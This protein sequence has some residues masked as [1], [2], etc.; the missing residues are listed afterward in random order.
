MKI[1]F[2]NPDKV[3]GLLTIT[4]E[5]TDYK[6]EVEKTLKDYRKKANFPGFRPGMVPMGLIKRQFGASVKMDAINKFVGEQI[7]KYVKD[8]NINMLGQPMGSD[9]QEPQD[10]EKPAPYTFMFDIAVAPDFKIELNG[11]DKIV[12]YNIKVDDKLIDQQVEMFASRAGKYEAAETYQEGD[13]LKGDLRELDENGNKEGGIEVSEAMIMPSYIKVDDQKKLFDGAKVGDIIT[14]N[15]RK[16]YPD[17]DTEVSS[18]LKIK[19]EELKDHEGDFSFQVTEVSHF[20]NHAIDQEL[21]DSVFGKDVVKDEKGFR[22]K[23]AEGLKAQLQGDSDYR[24]LQD[25]REYCAKKVGQLTYPDELL[26]RILLAANK[27]KDEKFV[28]ENYDVSIKQLT[29]QLIRDQLLAANNIKVE[30]AD[31]QAV[32]SEMARAQF[33]QY[34]MNNVPDEYIE[35]Y[36]KKLLEKR[37]NVEDF[38]NRA[39]DMKLTQALKNVVKLDTKDISIE[40]FNKLGEEK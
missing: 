40:D 17:N 36:A 34:G 30:Q 1:S 33:I 37:E 15:P 10:L 22:D 2:E 4:V 11:K 21:F 5:E 8:N 29:W 32:A 9:K 35:N 28:D 23:I 18:L 12:Y 6:D 26:K 20:A 7:Y 16:A 19:K 38:A 31:V 13:M 24:F 14:F 3:N 25:V 39:S 27:G